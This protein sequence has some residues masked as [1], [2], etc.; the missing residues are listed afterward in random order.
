MFTD[1]VAWISNESGQIII[2]FV[3]RFENLSIEFEKILQ[4][5]GASAQLPHLKPSPRTDYRFYYDNATENLVGSY[6]RRDVDS[7]GYRF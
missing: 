2:V 4:V 7:F 1:Q 3:G 6:F 5:I